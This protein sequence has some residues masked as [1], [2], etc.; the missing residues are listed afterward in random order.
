MQYDVP[1]VGPSMKLDSTGIT[2]LAGDPDGVMTLRAGPELVGP[3]IELN[4]Q[5]GITL[6]AGAPGVGSSITLNPV[7]GITLRFG[8]YKLTINE[9]GITME[10]GQNS[11]GLL[12]TGLHGV[13]VSYFC[14]AGNDHTT[15]ATT[16]V[17]SID[18]DVVRT[19][20]IQS[21]V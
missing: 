12:T 15:Y 10:V 3:R 9:E 13:F 18:G 16:L 5:T 2:L 20:G 19:A 7:T 1:E 11:L 4:P 14:F 8:E 6:Q 17:E 21:Q